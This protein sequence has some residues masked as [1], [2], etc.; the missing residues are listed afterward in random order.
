MWT[1]NE[2][3]AKNC[4]AFYIGSAANE[5]G[6]P[7]NYFLLNPS[8]PSGYMKAVITDF[9][10]PSGPFNTEVG[11]AASLNATDS[12]P[13]TD[14]LALYTIV[15]TENT[16][17]GY[18]NGEK[19]QTYDISRSIA[20]LGTNLLS[21]IG[22]S[23]YPDIFYK[24]LVDDL[25]IY[26]AAL[27]DTEVSN[28]YLQELYTS[29]KLENALGDLVI[30]EA[31]GGSVSCS[32]VS[33]LTLPETMEKGRIAITWTSSNPSVISDSGTVQAPAELTEV[34]LTASI[35][36]QGN[37]LKKDYVLQVIPKG[38]TEYSMTIDTQNKGAQISQELFGLF[39]EDINSAADG[40][41]NPQLVKNNSF[42]NYFNVQS[43][44]EQGRGNQYSWRL[45]WVS[46][47]TDNFIVARDPD[48][49]MNE[50]NTNYATITG[51][52]TL[53]N[54]GFAP[55][56]TPNAAS[57]GI[58]EGQAYDFSIW[59]KSFE[60]YTGTLTVQ[61]V[62]ADGKPLTDAHSIPL[63][64]DGSWTKSET[65]VLTGTATE[66]GKLKLT[67][68]GAS[69]DDTLYLDMV[70][71][72]SQ[73]TYGYGN[74]NYSYGLGVRK[75]LVEML[76]VLDPS[77][78]RFPGGCII[79]GNSG[80]ES[81]YNWEWSIG[82]LEERK[83]I[84][85]HWASD[86][87]S[88]TNTYGYMQSFGFGYHEILQLCEDMG[89]E[90]FPILSAGVFCQFANGDNAPAASGEELDKFAQHATHL[91]DY[92]WGDPNSENETQALWASKRVA[93]GHEAPFNLNY[94]GIGNENWQA[95]YF[96]NFEYIKKYVEDYVAEN[97]PGRSITIIS[98]AG[99][100]A[101]GN[102]ITYAWKRL[103][104]NSPGETL[105]DE[106]YYQSRDFMLNNTDRYD[107]YNRLSAGGSNVFLGEYATHLDPR[108]NVLESAICDAAYMTGI[109]RNGDIVRHASYAPLFEK[110]GCA[111]WSTNLILF[112]DY[113]SM[114]TP[115]YYVQQM[116]AQN[117]GEQILN[118]TLSKI[119]EN[120]ERNTGSLVLG[121]WATS[122]YITNIKVTREDGT[123]LL[124][125]NFDGTSGAKWEAFPGSTGTFTIADGKMTFSQGSGM[126]CVWLPHTVNDP[127]WYNYKVEVTAV[128]TGGAEG[129][130]VGAGAKD[131]ANYYWYNIGGWDNTRSDVE[132]CRDGSK[133]TLGNKA[134]ANYVSVAT[135]DPMHI[136]FNYGADTKLQAYYTTDSGAD[137]VTLDGYLRPYQKDI[138][139]VSSMDDTYIYLKLVNHDT[140]SKY[141][142]LN[143]PNIDAAE[144]EI[145]CLSGNTTDYNTIGNETVVP[146]TTTQTLT[147][148]Q[149]IYE[150]P[151]MS[152]TVIK[153]AHGIEPENP[154]LPYKDVAETDWFYDAVAYTYYEELMTGMDKETF[155][156]YGQLSRA[157]F[158]LIL[159]RMEGSPSVE[160]DN[161][162][163]DISGDEW[164]GPAI[165]WA[166]KA[167]ITKGYESGY[168]G[169]ADPI[170]REQMALMMYRY[171]QY[172]EKE[173]AATGDYSTFAD[174]A[175]VSD[176]AAEGMK[177]AV[178]NGIITGKE[179]GTRIDPQGNTAR[180]ET[181]TI[182]QRFM[183]E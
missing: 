116:Y 98:S 122:G 19:Y 28:L 114:A 42:E 36:F 70:S 35:T 125:E 63:S 73:D 80:R 105:V 101:T 55:M 140:Y 131:S 26:D 107:Y 150:V 4:S 147:N 123:V 23:P 93:N 141:I 154:E 82:P 134:G 126:N 9:E 135:D 87:G 52:M 118:T 91:I 77:F 13:A 71:L 171:A 181:A 64:K 34:T 130:L 153:V 165:L 16:M 46:S 159:Y 180:A 86:N 113:D 18:L 117:Y 14:E 76:M 156:P 139:Q 22:Q 164:Y 166:A 138:Y 29:G 84:A 161:T 3:G 120:Y 8:N 132:C 167:G 152:F 12:F 20:D 174:A 160:T 57:M 109:E 136:T 137:V 32:A 104:E 146:V 94:V 10:N 83:A 175:N 102:N 79:E 5:H 56:S 49:Y 58:E 157:Q 127:E 89:A 176:F 178:G 88:Y 40:G 100:S 31:Q 53:E 6:Y 97:Y 59:T 142:T 24:G 92:C 148:G 168:F 128:K 108:N 124:E 65:L 129:F 75:D 163:K 60:G 143:Y 172:Q 33:Q 2:T 15:L 133:S 170:T 44:E 27:T 177:W 111:N 38:I 11:L 30:P 51:N 69:D 112:D 85:N 158:A 62:N 182:I 25:C 95:K 78:I 81:Y 74:K 121:T 103:N 183:A 106:H 155:G 115:N 1:Q 110:S 54:G 48:E 149:M 47:N 169:P 37:T 144:A 21:Y 17:T 162:F 43:I 151:G 68:S 72:S 173:V 67:I 96:D 7:T 119:G 66:K 50:N 45:H 179:N 39:F 145:I 61:V 99:P 41:L 90:P